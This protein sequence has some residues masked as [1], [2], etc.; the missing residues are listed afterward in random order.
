MAYILRVERK[1]WKK[2][3]FSNKIIITL[4]SSIFD[5]QIWN[6]VSGREVELSWFLILFIRIETRVPPHSLERVRSWTVHSSCL[7]HSLPHLSLFSPL[8]FWE[9]YSPSLMDHS[10]LPSMI[11]VASSSSQTGMKSIQFLFGCSFLLMTV[12][13]KVSHSIW[14][15]ILLGLRRMISNDSGLHKG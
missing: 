15:Q 13:V 4:Y 5:C 14:E 11:H 8:Y 1:G 6:W 2:K 9:Q 10:L 12:F 3:V 7:V